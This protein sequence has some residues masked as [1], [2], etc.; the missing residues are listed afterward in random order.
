MLPMPYDCFISFAS[1][2]LEK[3]EELNRRM[4]AA[5]FSV[6]FDKAH[7]RERHGSQWHAEIEAGCES[8]RVVLPVL[9]PRWKESEWTRYETY[10]AES[11]IP[12]V[13]EGAWDDVKTPP[14]TRWQG[15]AVGADD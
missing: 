8:S 10:G 2:D 9:T 3:A 7:L 4:I 15:A 14:L 1:P 12:I 5:G 11:V 13:F 6:W